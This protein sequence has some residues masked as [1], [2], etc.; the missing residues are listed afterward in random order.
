MTFRIDIG[1]YFGGYSRKPLC[2]IPV[3]LR[4]IFAVGHIR[5]VDRTVSRVVNSV[6]GSSNPHEPSC[7]E[8][9]R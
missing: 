7:A 6:V 2:R 9:Q 3:R 8:M 5:L 1:F 4:D